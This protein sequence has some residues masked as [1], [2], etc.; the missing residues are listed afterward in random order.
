MVKQS[1]KCGT[2]WAK[3]QQKKSRI[4]DQK[5]ERKN[6]LKVLEANETFICTGQQTILYNLIQ[7]AGCPVS[8]YLAAC[9]LSCS[10]YLAEG[11]TNVL[12]TISRCSLVMEC[13]TIWHS[14]ELVWPSTD[15]ASLPSFMFWGCPVGWTPILETLSHFRT[16]NTQPWR[17]PEQEPNE[18]MCAI[19][20]PSIHGDVFVGTGSLWPYWSKH[21]YPYYK[22]LTRGG[23]LW[24]QVKR[25]LFTNTN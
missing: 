10:K 12:Q 25:L 17:V 8:S 14:A 23:S 20:T 7:Y 2:K 15:K 6:V 1:S 4:K 19:D 3:I 9:L 16:L 13:C 21:H 18:K 5:E 11:M 22:A 24:C